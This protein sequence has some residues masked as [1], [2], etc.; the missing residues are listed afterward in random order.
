MQDGRVKN[1]LFVSDPY[2]E[3]LLDGIVRFARE[4]DWALRSLMRRNGKFPSLTKPDGIVATIEQAAVLKRLGGLRCP[5]VQMLDIRNDS[6]LRYPVV[7]PDYAALGTLGAQY[8]LRLGRPHFAFY[9]R[10]DFPDSNAIRDGFERALQAHK[11]AVIRLDYPSEYPGLRS[12]IGEIIPDA[13]WERA[14]TAKLR[15]LPK[16]CAIMAEDDRWGTQLIRLAL[17][18]GLRVPQ[19]IAV[20]GCDNHHPEVDL[21]RVPMSSVDANLSG[22]GY[23]AAELLDR[24]MHGA[25]VP[26]GPVIVPPLDV[27]ARDSTATFVCDDP[28]LAAVVCRIRRDYAEPLTIGT[29]AREA[30]MSTRSLQVA[31]RASVGHAVREEINHCRMQRAAK[32]LEDTDLK[33]A[34]VA[35][36]SG[37]KEARS[38]GRI[39]QHEHGQTPHGFRLA[40][41]TRRH[42]HSGESPT[43]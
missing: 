18:S 34:A 22:D 39:F 25:R 6:R 33:L 41:R 13:Q 15:K 10:F 2:I 24:L 16:P 8:L 43:S 1:V 19:D 11:C 38:L 12:G 23:A 29:L 14:L 7:M 20:L 21:A 5:V 35:V 28:R 30:G 27:V 31:F 32:L 36:E 4:H 9:R 3:P 40:A 17:H 42:T 26:A 37:F